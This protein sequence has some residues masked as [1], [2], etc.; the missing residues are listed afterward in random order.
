[1]TDQKEFM[2]R[3]IYLL[4]ITVALSVSVFAQTAKKKVAALPTSVANLSGE[5]SDKL[6]NEPVIKLRLQKLLGKKSFASFMESFETLTPITKDGNFLFASGCLIHACTHLESS[7]AIN[8]KNN[9]IHAAIFNDDKPTRFFNERSK[10]SPKPIVAWA[11]KLN[12]LKGN[13]R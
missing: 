12:D 2:K 9:T 1:M 3:I 6:L 7:I 4:L 10:K 5:S 13:N 8:L 11:N